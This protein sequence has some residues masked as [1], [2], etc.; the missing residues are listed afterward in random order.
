MRSTIRPAD[1][2]L[3][4]RGRATQRPWAVCTALLAAASLST[5]ADATTWRCGNTYTDRPCESGRPLDPRDARSLDDRQA[6]EAATRRLKADA[7]RMERE[8]LAFERGADPMAP[9]GPRRSQRPRV[10]PDRA[11]VR[12]TTGRSGGMPPP[13]KKEHVLGDG[14][15]PHDFVAVAPAAPGAGLAP[16]ARKKKP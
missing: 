10:A 3:S 7:D 11:D 14:V 8:R 1:A 5:P 2:V 13:R 6:A 12:P 9:A 4:R 16:R 15:R